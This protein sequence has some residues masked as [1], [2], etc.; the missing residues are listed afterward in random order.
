MGRANEG[1]LGFVYLVWRDKLFFIGRGGGGVACLY[2]GESGWK[3]DKEPCTILRQLARTSAPI[4]P[5]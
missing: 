4:G 5:V 2:D 1:P 3:G